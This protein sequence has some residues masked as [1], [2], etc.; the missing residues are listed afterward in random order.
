LATYRGDRKSQVPFQNVTDHFLS[1]ETNVFLGE[2]RIK[3]I[4]GFHKNLREEIETG[5]EFVDLGLNQTNFMYDVKYFKALSPNLEAIFG[6]QGFL[7]K[8]IN[9]ADALEYLIPDAKKDDR[10]L[11]GL[12]N[13]NTEKWVIQ[14]GLRYDYRKLNVDAR[15]PHFIDFGFIWLKHYFLDTEHKNSTY[16]NYYIILNGID[17]PVI[18]R[19]LQNLMEE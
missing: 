14:G 16:K 1:S 6:I 11:Y 4:F 15:A 3:A 8:T 9:Y 2:D 7:L 5:G 13:Y 12:L 19:Q 17:T 18:A 10:S